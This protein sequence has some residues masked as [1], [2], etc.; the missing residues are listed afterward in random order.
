MKAIRWLGALQRFATAFRRTYLSPIRSKKTY[1]QCGEDA[2]LLY[3]FKSRKTPGF[4][5][6]VGCHHP[7]RGSNTYALYRKGWKG[8][9][10]D[11]EAD[12][13]LS[14]KLA[15]PRD[16]VLLSAV[17]DRS[18][19]VTIFAPKAYSVL[20]SI[21]PDVSTSDGF[22]A[23]GQITTRTL[24]EIL[25]EL[26]APLDFQLLSIDAEG[27]DLKV[28]KGLGLDRYS[29]EIVCVEDNQASG[30]EDYQAGETYLYLRQK[31]YELI[32]L[33]GPS[34]IFRRLKTGEQERERHL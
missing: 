33:I 3:F 9:L 23:V 27:V 11:M 6:D 17:S 8:V 1:S 16:Q 5:V 21:N 15:R 34:M 22:Q 24:G 10:I 28:L 30:I 12:K 31:N 18:E 32:G 14:C 19:Q 7:K 4:Y 20:A 25:D 26:K 29:P 13:V 2:F